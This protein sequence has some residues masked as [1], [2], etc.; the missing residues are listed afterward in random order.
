[1]KV[2]IVARPDHSIS[3]YKNMSDISRF[4]ID[5]YT[6]YSFRS[7]TLLNRLFPSR[8]SVPDSA[9]VLN[10]YT[11]ISYLVLRYGR[12]LGMNWREIERVLFNYL[13]PGK[14]IKTCDVLH[15]WPFY[16]CDLA[17]QAK[18]EGVATVAEYYEA[19]PDFVNSIYKEEYDK[20]GI[21]NSAYVNMMIDQN[22]SF[23]FESDFIVA[24][25]FTKMSYAKKYPDKNYH[26]CSYGTAGYQLASGVE[27][28]LEKFG[29]AHGVKKI[30]SV[31][32]V[33]VEKG[34]HY[35]IEAVK[36][37]NVELH[38]IGAIKNG[39]E[40]VFNSLD[41]ENVTF[42]GP[43]RHVQVLNMLSDFDIMCLPSLSDNYSISVTE[44]LSRGLPVIVTS[45]CGN[46]DDVVDYCLGVVVPPK[47]VEG[48][49]K[50]IDDVIFRF[51]RST[52]HQSLK[53]FFSDDRLMDYPLSVLNVYEKI[54]EEKI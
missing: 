1:M 21:K 17:R 48:L 32:A 25:E 8:K 2:N 44:G 10:L 41:C 47:S 20:F 14:R 26:V 13:S 36:G 18:L 40:H 6:F 11:L 52:F 35:L 31:G 33:S 28:K 37:L 45:N 43:K 53:R 12:R 34:T 42:H 4:D 19:E 16:S 7:G 9:N 15:Y 39:Q 51:D 5:L 49:K 3:L 29:G 54:V 24:S 30:V 22:E 46:A 23:Q 50:A 27:A 38:L